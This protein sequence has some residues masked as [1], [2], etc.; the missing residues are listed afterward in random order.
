[1]LLYYFWKMDGEQLQILKELIVS[2][3]PLGVLTVIVLAVILF[4]ICTATESA[5][6]GALGALY[7]AVMARDARM[8]GWW[9][10]AARCWASRS[11]GT[12]RR[13][14]PPCWW[15]LIGGPSW[16]PWCPLSGISARPG[17][18]GKPQAVHLPHRQDH[19]HGVLALRGLGALLGGV[20]AARRPGLIERWVL[21]LNLS[22]LAS[23][24]SPS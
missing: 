8:V 6:I 21:E 17:A 18:A 13:P 10:L 14:S 4:G 22:P 15:R 19:R 16:A 3:V 2:V 11:A 12:R 9:S 20:R 23:R 7:L 24:S 1:V 5:A